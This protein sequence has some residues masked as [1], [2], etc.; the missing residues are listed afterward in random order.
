MKFAQTICSC[1]FIN[2]LVICSSSQIKT[3]EKEQD[4][5]PTET[6]RRTATKVLNAQETE[7][8]I[9]WRVAVSIDYFLKTFQHA[10]RV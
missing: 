10:F 8:P 1:D 4:K 6:Q 9:S 7:I 5:K 2:F 3:V